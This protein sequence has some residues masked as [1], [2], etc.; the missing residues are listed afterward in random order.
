MSTREIKHHYAGVLVVTE[1]GK[2]IGQQRD[3]KV[4]IDNPGKVATFGGTVEDGEDYRFAAWRELVKEET[5]LTSPEDELILFYEDE[6]WRP[7]TSEWEAR[8]FYVVKI[9]DEQLKTLKVYEGQDWVE[10]KGSDDTNLVDAWRNVI[11]AY[12]KLVN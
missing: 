9:S 11:E 3:D 8:H 1:N 12:V 7:L 6:S 2:M 10:I 4:G 5:N